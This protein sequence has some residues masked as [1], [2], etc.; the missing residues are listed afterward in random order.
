MI[1]RIWHGWTT[2]GNADRYESLL[3]SEIFTGIADRAIPGYQGIELLR[4]EHPDQ[5][6]FVTMMWFDS[7][8]SVRAFA[9]EDYQASV[10]PEPARRL[11]LEFD[12]RSAHYQVRQPK[13]AVAQRLGSIP[14][15]SPDGFRVRG[16]TRADAAIIA[17]HRAR[18]FE[19][20]GR[21][22]PQAVEPL[23]ARSEEYLR[24]A[25]ET[26]EYAGWLVSPASSPDTVAAGAGA[27][28]RRVLPHPK[29]QSDGRVVVAEGRHAIV[30]NVFT[31]PAWRRQGLGT[32]V[33]RHVIAWA[34]R[35]R[36]DALV[37]H[38]SDEG[39]PLYQ[40]LGFVPT[41]EMRFTG[42][43]DGPEPPDGEGAP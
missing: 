7:L 11:L 41:N 19:Q 21:V 9:G 18:M 2:R 6:E 30:L 33:M 4:C 42:S 1:C 10:V 27:Q 20:M 38:A 5:V 24:R 17:S 36:L 15:A 13:G 31:E 12:A 8:E 34:A 14:R 43:L 40:R 39:R 29:R 28:R 37:L 3:K 16:A 22:P 23:R 26:G 35:E 25:L 32:L